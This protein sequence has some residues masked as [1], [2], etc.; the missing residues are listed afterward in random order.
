MVKKKNFLSTPQQTV[1]GRHH[2]TLRGG[3]FSLPNQ[4]SDSWKHSVNTGPTLWC[5]Q[6]LLDQALL[7]GREREGAVRPRAQ[8]LG[9]DGLLTNQRGGGG[10]GGGGGEHVVSAASCVI[11]RLVVFLRM[12]EK[13]NVISLCREDLASVGCRHSLY[14]FCLVSHRHFDKSIIVSF[15]CDDSLSQTSSY[16]HPL[17]PQLVLFKQFEWHCRNQ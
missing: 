14:L 12:R 2:P 10:G 6:A 15:I 8:R 5:V 1:S 13:K 4:L 16:S 3:G 7:E 9:A 17:Q 11:E